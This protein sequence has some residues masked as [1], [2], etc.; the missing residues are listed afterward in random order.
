[1]FMATV[2]TCFESASNSAC[3]SSIAPRIS[4][5][6]PL[7]SSVSFTFAA[8]R[9]MPRYCCSSVRRLR[10]RASWS[11]YCL[12]T[13]WASMLS[14]STRRGSLRIWGGTSG[15]VA[16]GTR[17]VSEA[18]VASAP[19]LT[20]DATRKLSNLFIGLRGSFHNQAEGGS[21]HE[22][23]VRRRA[24]YLSTAAF[25]GRRGGD[26]I[27]HYDCP[28]DRSASNNI[29]RNRSASGVW[30]DRGLMPQREWLPT[31]SSTHGGK[32]GCLL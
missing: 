22:L 3:L 12:V 4:F 30:E 31:H 17:M 13:S 2:S 24:F 26:Q 20:F 23:A 28:V 10:K 1:M 7:T 32:A 14:F 5:N 6:L 8:V 25:F 9:R 16:R 15:N 21:A 27:V 29:F 19:P 18:L 11:T